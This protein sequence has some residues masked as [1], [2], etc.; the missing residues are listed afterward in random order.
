[1]CIFSYDGTDRIRFTGQ[2]DQVQ[3]QLAAAST[4]KIDLYCDWQYY[5]TKSEF[6]K[7]QFIAV[8]HY[9]P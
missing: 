3:S 5:S 9:T 7:F 2:D 1:M 4:P 6:V 8:L